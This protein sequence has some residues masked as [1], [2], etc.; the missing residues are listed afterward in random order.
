MS[1]LT[2]GQQSTTG[3]SN[4]VNNYSREDIGLTLTV[5]PR[6]SSNNQVSLKIEVKVED[7]DPSSAQIADR[8]T[9]TKRTVKTNAIVKNGETII[10]GGLIKKVS[11]AGKSKVPFF[12]ELPVL[13][14]LLFTHTSDVERQKNVI[15]YLTPYIVRSSGDLQK[16]KTLLSELDKVQEQYNTIV[17]AELEKRGSSAFSSRGSASGRIRRSP[18]VYRGPIPTVTETTTKGLR[19]PRIYQSR[20]KKV[21]APVQVTAPKTKA[22]SRIATTSTAATEVVARPAT[23]EEEGFFSSLFSSAETPDTTHASQ[24]G[25][26]GPYHPDFGEK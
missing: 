5:Q 6:L 2:Q 21:S 7:L 22:S 23:K 13:G 15:I 26:R 25:S 17:L 1:I 14:D 12:S 10:L 18:D 4:I 9:T 20:E 24:Q 8:P 16:L 3:V 19:G 11:G